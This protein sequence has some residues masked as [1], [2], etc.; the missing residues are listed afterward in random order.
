MAPVCELPRYRHVR[1]THQDGRHR[2]EVPVPGLDPAPAWSTAA[3]SRELSAVHAR[4]AIV[5]LGATSF[6]ID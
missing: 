1:T 6:L 3:S 4:Q 2:A 5:N